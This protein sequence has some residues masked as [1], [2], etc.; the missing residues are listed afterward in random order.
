MKRLILKHKCVSFVSIAMSFIVFV[1]PVLAQQ[2][3]LMA[4]RIAG[5][6]AA[7]ADVSGGLWFIAGCLGGVIGVVVAY[8]FEPNPPATYLLGKSP[9]YVAAYTDAYR[10]TAKSVQTSRAITGCIVESLLSVLLYAL[11]IAAAD[12]VD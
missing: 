5:E 6:Q 1:M 10:A 12:S 8:V 4:G 9:E 11:L 2:D 7:R 3:D